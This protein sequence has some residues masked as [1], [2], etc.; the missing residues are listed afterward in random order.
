MTTITI[1]SG[2]TSVS[3]H[4]PNTTAYLVEGSGAL[5]IVSAARFRVRLRS[6]AAVS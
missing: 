5:D 1:S 3:S 6:K 4:I 2:T